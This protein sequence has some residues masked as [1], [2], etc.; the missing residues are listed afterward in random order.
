MNT[1]A[2]EKPAGETARTVKPVAVI[3][4]GTSSV[5]M[6][7][8]EIASTGDVRVLEHLTQAV[9]L[10]KD[11]FTRGAIAKST[12]EDCVRVLK[13]YRRILREYQIES[14]DQIRVV[15]TSAVREASNMLAFVDRVYIAT[16]LHVEPIDEA[17]VNRITFLGIQPFLG[18]DP[19]LSKSRCVVI[20]IG[21]GSTE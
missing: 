2:T 5:R 20:D 17:E 18:A 15:A 13:S 19:V 11:T 4:I 10:G 16:G 1:H 21:G 14:T 3:D 9:N 6:A 8:A 7:I 12:I